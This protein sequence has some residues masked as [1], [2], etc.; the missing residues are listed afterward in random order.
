MQVR[1]SSVLASTSAGLLSSAEGHRLLIQC[2]L[3]CLSDCQGSFPCCL[4]FGGFCW[5]HDVCQLCETLGVAITVTAGLLLFITDGLCLCTDHR[6]DV[7]RCSCG[8]VCCARNSVLDSS[9]T[10]T[11]SFQPCNSPTPFDN[12][13]IASWLIIGRTVNNVFL[14]V[15]RLRAMLPDVIDDVEKEFG[16]RRESLF[17]AFFVFFQKFS[18]GV[19]LGLSTVALE[20]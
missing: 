14:L 16:M 19:S 12:S 3:E 1:Y 17:Y 15:L 2:S 5:S 20:V 9:V 10:C 7:L 6:A 18:V 8:D 13:C 11:F 4:S